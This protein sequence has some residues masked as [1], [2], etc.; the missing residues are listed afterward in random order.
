MESIVRCIL[1]RGQTIW[2]DSKLTAPQ[3]N[4]LQPGHLSPH[5]VHA[6]KQSRHVHH[7]RLRPTPVRP[8]TRRLAGHLRR[9]SPQPVS[10]GYERS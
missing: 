3:H 6:T 4:K 5:R 9:I 10:T 2:R 8:R 7:A 1:Q